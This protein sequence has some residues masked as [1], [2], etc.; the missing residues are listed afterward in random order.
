MLFVGKDLTVDVYLLARAARRAGRISRSLRRRLPGARIFFTV[1][2]PEG[3]AG[4]S[5][6]WRLMKAQLSR[7]VP[8]GR[9]R[10]ST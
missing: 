8:T 3:Y 9:L 4:H 5:T 7:R 6:R 1:T 10:D 2:P